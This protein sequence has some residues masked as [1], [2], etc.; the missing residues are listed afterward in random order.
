M[1]YDLCVGTLAGL[2]IKR[3]TNYPNP[4]YQ[5]KIT[6]AKNTMDLGPG[7]SYD[8]SELRFK[9]VRIKRN[10]FVLGLTNP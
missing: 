10:P 4:I 5:N 9:R 1:M 7:N 2:R 3:T 8:L 6:D